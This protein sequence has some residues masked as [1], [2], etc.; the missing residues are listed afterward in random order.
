M[1]RFL[2]LSIYGLFLHRNGKFCTY[3]SSSYLPQPVGRWCLC[4]VLLNEFGA[5]REVG[6]FYFE[7]FDHIDK[8]R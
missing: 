1:K 5:Y 3:P 2:A 6:P 7:F 8:I 4:T